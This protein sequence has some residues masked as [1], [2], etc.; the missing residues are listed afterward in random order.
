[1]SSSPGQQVRHLSPEEK[2]NDR[3]EVLHQAPGDRVLE[4]GLLTS[5]FG[6]DC[7]LQLV[8][9][10]DQLLSRVY[11]RWTGGETS[12]SQRWRLKG[13]ESTSQMLFH[14]EDVMFRVYG[15][16]RW[17]P[18]PGYFLRRLSGPDGS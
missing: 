11:R 12:Q 10:R 8:E 14:T 15:G 13:P 5:G 6:F 2:K 18:L 17:K 1:M 16:R 4:E 7:S 3:N 9:L